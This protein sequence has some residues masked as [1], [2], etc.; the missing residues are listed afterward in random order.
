MHGF[1]SGLGEEVVFT[2]TVSRPT[3]TIF[4]PSTGVKTKWWGEKLGQSI[5]QDGVTQGRR[6]QETLQTGKG[7]TDESESRS[8]GG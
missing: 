4:G 3:S 6:F 5:L 7:T 1:I 8:D 2:V